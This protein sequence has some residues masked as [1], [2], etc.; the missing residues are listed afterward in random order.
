MA[1]MTRWRSPGGVPGEDVASYYRRRAE[2]EIGLILSEGTVVDRP[3]ARNEPDIPFFHGTDALAGWKNV[4]D[5]VHRV[6]GKMGPQLWH[7]GAMPSEWTPWVPDAPSESPSG[8][9]AA[10]QSAGKAT[11]EEDVADT[12]AAFGRAAA[13]A[14]R[15]KFDVIEIH[16]AHGYLIDQFF[17]SETNMRDD[18]YGGAS[19]RERV[20]FGADVIKAVRAGAGPDMPVI[21]RLSRWKQ[22][23][24]SVR[25]VHTPA[26]MAEWLLPLVEAGADVLHCSQRRIWEPEFPEIDGEHGL[27]FAGWAKKLT[28]AATISVGLVGLSGDAVG[29]FLGESSVPTGLEGV[30]RQLDRE[31]FDLVAVGRALLADPDWA[32]KVH[33][34]EVAN[35]RSFSPAALNTL[36]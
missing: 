30:A 17:W 27:N 15:L 24:Y 32:K 4:I 3:A 23:D 12:I 8:L 1:P 10:R 29:A 21:L 20:R 28:G 14:R 34:R 2:N 35:L 7:V 33:V 19:L 18:A 9:M 6:G 22:Q 26:A 25:L 11:S 5:E 36:V 16:G 31:E 13:A